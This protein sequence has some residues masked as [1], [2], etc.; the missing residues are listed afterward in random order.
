MQTVFTALKQGTQS[1]H[2]ALE[3][4]Y[5]FSVYQVN[6]A[7][8]TKSY[9]DVLSVM[10]LFHKK[11]TQ[12]VNSDSVP[13]EVA[14]LAM[15]LNGNTVLNALEQ[16][17][18]ILGSSHRCNSHDVENDNDESLATLNSVNFALSFESQT[19]MAIAAMY[20]WLGSSM[21]ANVLLR[22]LTSTPGLPVYY[23]GAMAECAKAWVQFKQQVDTLMPQ[24]ETQQEN[25]E[26]SIV[27]DAQRWFDYL[28]QLGVHV[29]SGKAPATV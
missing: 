16:D 4:T 6:K 23:Y 9:F 17:K 10:T 1:Q 26:A 25:V 21:G 22:R 13:K 11:V 14:N 5:P 15:L 24:L 7:P 2:S 19:S 3:S 20:V 8:D 29:S 28:I 18:E 12:A 27:K